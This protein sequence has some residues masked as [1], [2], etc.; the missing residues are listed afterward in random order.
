MRTLTYV[1]VATLTR[2]SLDEVLHHHPEVHSR[3]RQA[4]LTTAMIRAFGIIARTS[5]R[6]AATRSRRLSQRNMLTDGLIRQ[7]R[8]ELPGT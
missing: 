5:Q 1:E 3:I 2:A 6:K 8:Q 4:G 7:A